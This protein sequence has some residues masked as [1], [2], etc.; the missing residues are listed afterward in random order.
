MVETHIQNHKSSD[1]KALPALAL[2]QQETA[3]LT[4]AVTSPASCDV[5]VVTITS[6]RFLRLPELLARLG[7]CRATIYLH[8]AAGKFPK[9]IALGPRA[10]G[11]LEH[12]I[13]AWLAAKMKTRHDKLQKSKCERAHKRTHIG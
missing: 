7:V 12:E 1:N 4:L 11:W 10:V 3:A 5:P 6:T 2:R 8:M 9:Q 13:D